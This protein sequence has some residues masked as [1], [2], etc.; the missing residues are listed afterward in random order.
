MSDLFLGFYLGVFSIILLFNLLWYIYNKERGYLYYF[1]LHLSVVLL[2]LDA[3]NVLKT[4]P[5]ILTISAILFSFL[6]AKEFLN[7]NKYYKNLDKIVTNIA[8][9]ISAV[10]FLLYITN[11]AIVIKNIPYSFIFLGLVILAINVY[12]KGFHLAK[13]FIIAWGVNLIIIFSS[14]INRIFG[15]KLLHFDYLSQIGNILEAVILSFALFAKT[16]ILTEEKN[17]KE[18]MLIHQSRLA[19]M[20]EML[21]NISHQWRQPL[22]RVASF[23]MNMQ[24]HIM[25]NYEKEKYLLT[26]LEESQAQLEYMSH[27]IDDFTNFYKKDKQKKKFYVNDVIQN[28]SNIILPTLNSNKIDLKI[29]TKN[30][31]ELYSYPKELAQVILNLIQNAKDAIFL[32]NIQNPQIEITVKNKQIVI[33]DNANGIEEEI[34]E[35]I[36]EPYFTT[37][38]KH[39]GTGLG[40]YMSKMILEKN[41]NARINVKNIEEGV[42]FKIDFLN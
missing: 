23:I 9:G 6:F 12:K 40:L 22:N 20:G 30:D 14:D 28:V 38:E 2:G 29:D 21:A 1:F 17:E 33:R 13:Y 3:Y 10:M 39:K 31:F 42:E 4:S 18:K 35:K 7:L 15:F 5:I 11:N 37:K 26:K 8:F 34:L 24:M 16:K 19:S 25:D 27:T 36:F 32:N 41:M